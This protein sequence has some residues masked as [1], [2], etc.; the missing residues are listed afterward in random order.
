EALNREADTKKE[1]AAERDE[2]DRELQ[3]DADI[4]RL[5]EAMN[6][7]DNFS[8]LKDRLLKLLAQSKASADSSDRRIA[9]R[10]LAGFSAGSRGTGNA[11][12]QELLDQIRPPGQFG[13]PQPGAPN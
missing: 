13:Q 11:K 5:R 9:R 10:V 4:Y 2:E 6:S 8:K 12:F 7:G 1:L 3:V